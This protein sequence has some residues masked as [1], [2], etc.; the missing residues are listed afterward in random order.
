MPVFL[1]WLRNRTLP[2]VL[3]NWRRLSALM[4]AGFAMLTG[5]GLIL[6]GDVRPVN[7][8]PKNPPLVAAIAALPR[9]TV[10]G[11]FIRDLD[12]SPVFTNRSTLFNRELTIAYQRGYFVPILQRMQAMR[13]LILTQ[14]PAVL[15]DRIEILKIDRL[16]IEQDTLAHPRVPLA[17][18]T[19]FGNDL[20]AMEEATT[21]NG[22]SLVA[23][24]APRCTGG[25]FGDVLLVDTACMLRQLGA[26]Q[27][28]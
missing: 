15:R 6:A 2:V 19:F 18:R 12:F 17:F 16:V 23:Q 20:S 11:G 24:L 7:F 1:A 28:Q 27:Q 10:V 8:T 9:E 14:D 22:P 3:K 25:M 26:H 4:I 5:G 13:D 21:S